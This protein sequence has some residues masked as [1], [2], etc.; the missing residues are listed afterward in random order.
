MATSLASAFPT[1]YILV[2]MRD[3]DLRASLAQIGPQKPGLVYGGE[4]I[5][6]RR[7]AAICTELGIDFDQRE[8][9]TLQEACSLLWLEHPARALEL[10]A[11]NDV[12]SVLELAQLCCTTPTAI[13]KEL[14]SKPKPKPKPKPRGRGTDRKH[15]T[16]EVTRAARSQPKMI[17]RLF[18]LEPELYAYAKEAAAQKGHNNVNKLVRAALWKEVALT[19]PN[20]P[21]FQPR[22]VQSAN[23]PR[24]M[25]RRR[26]TG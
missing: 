19:V 23:G 6:G 25:P 20:A 13:A 10:A 8:C 15:A 5:D 26:R 14:A 21:Q 24:E 17:R 9:A 18:V 12:R 2:R 3:R 7:R 1:V 22:R 16:M 11:A 4:P